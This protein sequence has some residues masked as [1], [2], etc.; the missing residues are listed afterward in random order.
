MNYI[1][2]NNGIKIPSI[3]IGTFMLNSIDAENSFYKA[4]KTGY[5]LIDT[6]NSYINE[7]GVGRGIKETG[8]SREEILNKCEIIPQVAQVECH[9]LIK[10]IDII[11]EQKNYALWKP[12]YE[13]Q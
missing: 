9:L 6:A 8:I 1:E 5:K 7:R 3:G 4:L 2:L 11:M 12:E 13:K 10:K